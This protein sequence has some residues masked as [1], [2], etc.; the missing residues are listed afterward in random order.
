MTASLS[1]A[2]SVVVILTVVI[3]ILVITNIVVVN[4]ARV[5]AILLCDCHTFAVVNDGNLVITTIVVRGGK[6]HA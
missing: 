2:L 3:H 6:R 1:L 5:G 4:G